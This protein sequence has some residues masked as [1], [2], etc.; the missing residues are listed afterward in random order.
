MPAAATPYTYSS[1][2]RHPGDTIHV[3]V[4]LIWCLLILPTQCNASSLDPVSTVYS[5]QITS[6]DVTDNGQM[7]DAKRFRVTMYRPV[8]YKAS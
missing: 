6:Y 8:E 7:S 5:Q 1:T 3:T 2:I 4:E